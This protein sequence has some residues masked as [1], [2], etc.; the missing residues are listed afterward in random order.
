MKLMWKEREGA[1]F[2][3]MHSRLSFFLQTKWFVIYWILIKHIAN[4]VNSFR[5]HVHLGF[6]KLHQSYV[7]PPWH[8]QPTWFKFTQWIR[9]K[10]NCI[11]KKIKESHKNANVIYI[12]CVRFKG[13]FFSV[14]L[15]LNKSKIACWEMRSNNARG[16]WTFVWIESGWR[17]N[18]N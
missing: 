9:T 13:A 5:A 12:S 4:I 11:W 6:E 14:Y 8:I 18:V 2:E 16:I 10:K 3:L 7:T 17:R 15:C 1:W